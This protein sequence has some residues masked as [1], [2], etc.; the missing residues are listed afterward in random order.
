MILIGLLVC[1]MAQKG[2]PHCIQQDG[3]Q[4]CFTPFQAAMYEWIKGTQR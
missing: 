3:I 4:I 1:K 2:I